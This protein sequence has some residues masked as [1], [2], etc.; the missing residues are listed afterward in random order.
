MNLDTWNGLAPDQQAAINDVS[1][2]TVSDAAA[3]FYDRA[4][5]TAA[6]R[7]AEAGIIKI[8]LGDEQ[9]DEWKQATRSVVDD[10]VG[11]NP[12]FDARAMYERM[13]ELA[14]G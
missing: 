7:N 2:R 11:D 8:V 6:E 10:W 4:S 5:I 14:A 1:A 9:L 3:G 13:L 12:G